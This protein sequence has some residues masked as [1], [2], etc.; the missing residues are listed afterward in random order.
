MVKQIDVQSAY[1]IDYYLI[2]I[3]RLKNDVNGNL[4]YKAF[5]SNLS[6]VEASKEA[7]VY[8]FTGHCS[9][10]KQEAEWILNYHRKKCLQ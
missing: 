7:F 9:G 4:R 5:I 8:T 3:E 10:E 6:G 2:T 1:L